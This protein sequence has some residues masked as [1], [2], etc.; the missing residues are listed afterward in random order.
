MKIGVII[1]FALV[2]SLVMGSFPL[3]LVAN[4]FSY[5]AWFL[6]WVGRGIDWFGWGGILGFE[7]LDYGILSLGGII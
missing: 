7:S 4:I 2:L 1:C 6:R 3:I 5:I